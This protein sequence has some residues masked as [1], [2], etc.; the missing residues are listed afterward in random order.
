[1]PLSK[2]FQTPFGIPATYWV[3]ISYD[4]NMET[5]GVL[6]LN[7]FYD[8]S[9]VEAAPLATQVLT[10]SAPDYSPNLTP[11]QLEQFVLTRPEWAGG[12]QV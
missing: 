9:T 7:G 3:I 12:T 11:S 10:I 6:I 2:S 4:D 1:M 5:S 8:A